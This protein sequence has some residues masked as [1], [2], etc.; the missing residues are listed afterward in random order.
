MEI[1]GVEL[2]L[3][4]FLIH[5][6]EG[7]NL[8]LKGTL[9]RV[10]SESLNESVYCSESSVSCFLCFVSS[11]L[12]VVSRL[13][14]SVSSVLSSI[15]SVLSSLHSSIKSF[16]VSIDGLNVSKNTGNLSIDSLNLS[17][18]GRNG[19]LCNPETGRK[20][21]ELSIE[22]SNSLLGCKSRINILLGSKSLDS[23]LNAA[24]LTVDS[25]N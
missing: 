14:G 9:N 11:G 16:D 1:S 10:C 12:S 21:S 6:H 23:S 4:K 13:L 17:V 24:D 25:V 5:F 8:C 2:L 15:S 22:V 7:S 19:R 20:F 18:D 3:V